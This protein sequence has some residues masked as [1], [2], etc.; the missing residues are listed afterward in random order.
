[1]REERKLKL[2]PKLTHEVTSGGSNPP[3]GTGPG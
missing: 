3:P 1:M 2:K